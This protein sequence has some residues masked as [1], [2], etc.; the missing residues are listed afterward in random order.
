MY[1]SVCYIWIY[2]SVNVAVPITYFQLVFYG[3]VRAAHVDFTE[4]TL[5]A[6]KH[7]YVYRWDPDW[8]TMPYPPAKGSFAIY[9]I[10]N[11]YSSVNYA[12]QQVPC[13]KCII[14]K[15]A[16]IYAYA[17]TFALREWKFRNMFTESQAHTKIN[18]CAWNLFKLC[19]NRR[20]REN[21]HRNRG[22]KTLV[23]DKKLLSTQELQNKNFYVLCNAVVQLYR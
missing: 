5:L 23:I 19:M 12:L 17:I 6:F 18:I 2:A 11:F 7:I 4:T 21:C 22:T 15:S 1:L 16:S 9:T 3:Y 14:L 8:E 10:E 13:Y 20:Y